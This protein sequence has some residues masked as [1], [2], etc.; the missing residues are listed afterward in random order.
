MADF[1][2]A[3]ADRFRRQMGASWQHL[4][5]A[6]PAGAIAHHSFHV[7]EVY[8]WVGLLAPYRGGDPLHI[9]DRCRIRWGQIVEVDGDQVV[10]RSRPL[11]WDGQQ[12]LLGAPAVETATRALDGLAMT[13]PLEAGQWVALHWDWVCDRL[14]PRQLEHLRAYSARQLAVTNRKLGHPGPAMTLG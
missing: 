11:E 4:A 10:V 8:P 3:I 13:D 9:L 5:E 6:I 2:S 7:F 12:L 1:G 14:S